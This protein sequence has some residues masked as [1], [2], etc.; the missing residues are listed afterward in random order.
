M[1]ANLAQFELADPA[2]ERVNLDEIIPELD[3]LGSYGYQLVRDIENLVRG[4]VMLQVQ[5]GQHVGPRSFPGYRDAKLP[6]GHYDASFGEWILP[7]EDVRTSADPDKTLLEFLEGTYGLAADLGR[8]D[9]A[10]LDVD[11]HRLDVHLYRGADRTT[12][13]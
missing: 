6:V 9:R 7:Y 4:Y 10:S 1:R 8:W 2:L 12:L 13:Y 3:I 5:I 11:P